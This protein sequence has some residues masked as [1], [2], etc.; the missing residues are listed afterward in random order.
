MRR[1]GTAF[2]AAAATLSGSMSA[3]ASSDDSS[4]ASREADSPSEETSE[5]SSGY[6][7]GSE[8][9]AVGGTAADWETASDQHTRGLK[10]GAHL[11]EDD[12]I[13]SG[14]AH[15]SP[16]ATLHAA[17]LRPA[18]AASQHFRLPRR[19]AVKVS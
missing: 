6:T 12:G 5:L 3:S 2:Q 16:G 1:N 4:G 15:S 14:Q 7:N 13:T 17:P 10:A 11:A 8:I 9:A 18:H 19:N